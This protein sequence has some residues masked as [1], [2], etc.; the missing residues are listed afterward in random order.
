MKDAAVKP[1]AEPR[2]ASS[3][4][5]GLAAWLQGIGLGQYEVMFCENDVDADV[6][7]SLT[8]ED[9]R[10]IG[11]SSIGHRRKLLQAIAALGAAA[12]PPAPKGADAG[13]PPAETAITSRPT[14]AERR[15][16]TI[17]FC[18]LAGST[19]LAARLDPEDLRD[20]MAAYRGVVTKAVRRHGGHVAQFLCDGVL[21]C[22]GWPRA[23]EHGAERAVRAGLAACEAVAQLQTPAGPLTARV[24]IA[25]GPVVVGALLGAGEARERG[26]VGDTP[27]LAARLQVLAGPGGGG[28]G[29]ADPVPDGSPVQV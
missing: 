25:T 8:A 4:S 26:V 17:L 21:A 12:G 27:N 28:V 29:R 3:K 1:S 10:D 9:L 15:Q 16:L 11:V 24:G 13:Q 23:D 18:D 5:L 2:A 20:A 7:P 19:A 22:F 6:L 14:G